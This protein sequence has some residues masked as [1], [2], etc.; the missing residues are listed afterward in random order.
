[1]ESFFTKCN[2]FL[3]R[4]VCF[5][6]LPMQR[7]QFL[8]RCQSTFLRHAM[9]NF[10][11]RRWKIHQQFVILSTSDDSSANPLST[12]LFIWTNFFSVQCWSTRSIDAKKVT[13]ERNPISSPRFP[14]PSCCTKVP[15]DSCRGSCRWTGSLYCVAFHSFYRFLVLESWLGK[16]LYSSR[17]FQGVKR[18]AHSSI[19]Q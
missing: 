19:K 1:M 6:L 5:Q 18:W 16:S 15:V 17:I 3:T 12:D 10:R 2:N 7:W 8:S 4:E 14:L 9:D 13:R 11:L